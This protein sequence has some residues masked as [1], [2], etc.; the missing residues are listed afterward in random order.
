MG[1][2]RTVNGDQPDREGSHRG[3]DLGP[4]EAE[5]GAFPRAP[6]RRARTP[7]CSAGRAAGPSCRPSARSSPRRPSPPRP[8]R[9]RRC[10]PRP[11]SRWRSRR[12]PRG[13]RWRR[14]A[15][16]CGCNWSFHGRRWNRSG[17][18]SCHPHPGRRAHRGPGRVRGCRD[19][20]PESHGPVFFLP[21][22]AAA[23][24]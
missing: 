2:K 19:R 11:T 3:A 8:H 17:R 5:A 6:S 13:S 4:H 18:R 23:L 1:Q 14:P 15:T 24:P 9:P 21:P 10:R 12:S 22:G 7:S 16:A 20:D